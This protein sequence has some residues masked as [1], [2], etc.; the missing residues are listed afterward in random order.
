MDFKS[1]AVIVLWVLSFFTLITGFWFKFSPPKKINYFFGFRTKNTMKN[2]DHWN[3]AHHFSG[4]LFLFF[5]IILFALGF[6]LSF[7]KF[8]QNLHDIGAIAIFI[9][10]VGFIVVKTE[11]ALKK[12]FGNK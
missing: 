11:L 7:S 12:K 2:Q 10:G 6:A 5:G 9:A 8:D 4:K 3:Y 1:S